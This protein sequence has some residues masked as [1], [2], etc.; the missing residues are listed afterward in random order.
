MVASWSTTVESLFKLD[1]ELDKAI[2]GLGSL[3]SI[4]QGHKSW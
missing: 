1:P 4:E 3:E 2:P